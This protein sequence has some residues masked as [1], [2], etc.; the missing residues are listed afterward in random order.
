MQP[1]GAG[2]LYPQGTRSQCTRFLGGLQVNSS[3]EAI[4]IQGVTENACLHNPYSH[5]RNH[6]VGHGDATV[7]YKSERIVRSAPATARQSPAARRR[8]PAALGTRREG[9]AR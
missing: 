5:V 3:L 7:G 4:E 1:I 6:P 2:R 9:G 8:T